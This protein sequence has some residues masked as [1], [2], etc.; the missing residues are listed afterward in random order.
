MHNHIFRFNSIRMGDAASK[1]TSLISVKDESV[2]WAGHEDKL[3]PST[4]TD[5]TTQFTFV[6]DINSPLGS[7]IA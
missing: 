6:F 4:I 1:W 3:N 2:F 7:R 5:M